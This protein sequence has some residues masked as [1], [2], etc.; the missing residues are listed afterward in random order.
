MKK[1]EYKV[2]IGLWKSIKNT[3][4]VWGV[5]ALVLLIDNWTQ[6][7]PEDYHKMAIPVIG[8]LAYFVKNKLQNK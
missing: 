7:I 5:P 8:L 1:P 6:W 3:L 2:S 4:I